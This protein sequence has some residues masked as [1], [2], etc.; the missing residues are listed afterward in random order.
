MTILVDAYSASTASFDRDIRAL[1]ER[2][3]MS[4]YDVYYADLDLGPRG[5]WQRVLAGAYTDPQVAQH[6]AERINLVVPGA[7]AHVVDVQLLR[8]GP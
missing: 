3:E 4:G 1:T 8:S 5:R 6:E 7:Q 2:L